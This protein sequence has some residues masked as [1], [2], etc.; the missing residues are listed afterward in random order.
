MKNKI[1]NIFFLFLISVVTGYICCHIGNN[2]T[3]Q[4]IQ[5]KDSKTQIERIANILEEWKEEDT[6]Q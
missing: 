5:Y 4:K 3:E 6:K 2:I 1:I